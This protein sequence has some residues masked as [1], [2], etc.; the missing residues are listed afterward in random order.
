[1]FFVAGAQAD[2]VRY[3]IQTES[4][5]PDDRGRCESSD[6]CGIRFDVG[7]TAGRHFGFASS[8]TADASAKL[9]TE[10]FEVL[11]AEFSVPLASMD[12]WNGLRNRH[13]RD[14]FEA[15]KF[16]LI[17]FKFTS[18]APVADKLT[19]GTKVTL[20]VKGLWQM[21]GVTKEIEVPVTVERVKGTELVR[22][23][24]ELALSLKEYNVVVPPFLGVRVADRVS[25][26][27]KL[28]LIPG[29]SGVSSGTH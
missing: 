16:P 1:M 6:V 28:N 21:H 2:V 14:A 7:F 12:T 18:A 15:D 23:Q 17:T 11:A 29:V 20:N 24:G 4:L 25:V 3:V 22:L 27:L 9:L 10:P 19:D 13:M 5:A 8:A 26:H